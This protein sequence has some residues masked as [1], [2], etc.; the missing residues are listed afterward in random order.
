MTTR[1]EL[2]KAIG[3]RYRAAPKSE[4]Q[5]IL[6][7]FVALTGCHRKHAIRA[8]NGMRAA[9]VEEKGRNRVYDE[10]T[11]QA[12]I[13]LWEAADRVCGKR[14]KALVPML[15]DAMERHGH[16]ELD[17]IVKDKVLAV[18]AATIDRML[19]GTRLQIDG[20]RKRRKGI[21]AAIRRSIPVR[22]FADWGDPPPGF[23]EIDMVEHYNGPKTDGDYLH[24]LVLTDIASGWTECIA[25]RHRS[26][27]LVIEG[28]AT[29]AEDLLFPML[30]VDSDNDSA[31]MTQDV[32]DYCVAHR[33]VQTRSRAYKKNDQAWV[34]QKNGAIVRRLV[35]YGRLSGSEATKTLAQLYASS[36]L[37]INFFQPSFKLKSKTRDG[38]RVKKVYHPPATPCDRLIAHPAVDPTVKAK[39]AAQFLSLDPVRLLQQIRIVQQALSDIATYGP[40]AQQATPTASPSPTPISEFLSSLTTAWKE[41]E[42]R[43][44][45]RKK[46]NAPRWWR[47]LVNPFAEAWPV[48]EGWLDADPSA[49][50]NELMD[51]LAA[52]TPEV[53]GSKAQLRTLQRRVGEWRSERAKEM[54][55]GSLRKAGAKTVEHQ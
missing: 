26:Q 32:F 47:T 44:T 46:S 50:A 38:A 3:A 7:E 6:D 21:G 25:M 42:V 17:L 12:L 13:M 24:T 16:L 9:D 45:H 53:Y 15:I 8:L 34:E 49:S 28:L 14:L 41:G 29:A 23:F 35:G 40:P 5:K 51:R 31:F 30:G 20:Q 54:V 19:A 55:L 4:K 43:P 48:I 2:T 27:A 37:Y 1:K 18:S 11:R 33:L 36:R 22:T 10:A 39:L 52:M